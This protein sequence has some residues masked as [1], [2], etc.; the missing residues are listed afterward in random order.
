MLIGVSACN[1]DNSTLSTVR[2]DDIE[3][4]GLTDQSVVSYVG[5][6]IEISPVISTGYAEDNLNYAWYLYE[7][8]MGELEDG[9]RTNRISSEKDLSYEVN[10]PSGSYTLV[11]EVTSISNNYVKT[12][13]VNLSVS[14]SFS[15]GFY[16]LKETP[17]GRTEVDLYGNDG[18]V[19]NLMGRF[20]GS[21]LQGKP[22]NLS[23]V[24]SGEYIDPDANK[25]ASANLVHVF[26]EDNVYRG[27]RSE[28]MKEVFNNSN[29]FYGGDIPA[30]ET[31]YLLFRTPNYTAYFSNTGIRTAKTASYG[32]AA[33]SGMMGYPV[34]E[35]G[36]SKH[37]QLLFYGMN[38]VYWSNEEHR[39]RTIDYRFNSP[40]LVGYNDETAYP[41]DLE[42]ISSG[43]N[44]MSDGEVVTAYFLCEQPST[45]NRYLLLLDTFSP[46]TIDRELGWAANLGFNA[47]RVFL[48]DVVWAHEGEKLFANM[49]KYLQIADRHGIKTL[50]VFF[51][52]CWNPESAYGK[53]PEPKLCKHNSGWVKSPS[54]KILNDKSQWGNLE[55][56][57]KAVITRFK[58]DGRIIGWDIYNEPGNVG[59]TVID[60][61][62]NAN[63]EVFFNTRELLEKA[64]VWARAANPSQPITSGEYVGDNHIV[65]KTF[66]K[67]QRDESDI[68]SF[69]CYGNAKAL[70]TVIKKLE[71]YNR[72]LFC[73]EYMA[74]PASTFNPC[75]GIMK[76]HKVAAFNWGLVSG[77]TQ[78]IYS[79]K[80][81]KMD[82]PTPDK[83]K[84]WF[85][86]V[87]F[88]SGVPYSQD[89]AD[90]IKKTMGKK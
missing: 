70:D 33:N 51:D 31:P 27:F 4:E 28:D 59:Y 47:M 15:Q 37:V 54:F 79:W 50:F 42:C 85:H 14:T 62:E 40:A 56:Y 9:Y 80:F 7:N 65:G 78:T 64:F 2:V 55:K 61:S 12:A 3:I 10:L 84:L 63:A 41:D 8:G 90:Y 58:D 57:V 75:L 68:I 89:E 46:E 52:S 30:N 49:E 48:S 77:K 21:A 82:N 19:P 67:L 34:D 24:Y 18:L 44:I 43:V 35:V 20:S 39:L 22:R 29:L 13:T 76:E 72:P 38:L 11:F 45:G 53:Q 73:T 26:T 16:I 87:F 36:T 81:N 74:R 32:Q 86:D 25:T 1:D 5:N 23:V 60:G 17:D 69:H 6:K 66:N 83:L 71:K 88:E